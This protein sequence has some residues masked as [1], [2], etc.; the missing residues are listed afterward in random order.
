M[1]NFKVSTEGKFKIVKRINN[2]YY[3]KSWKY[4][5]KK[6]MW[7]GWMYVRDTSNNIV[8]FKE[9]AEALKYVE[10]LKQDIDNKN[11]EEIV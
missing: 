5:I 3:D 6:K 1:L 11:Y 7:I 2:N 10:K 8:M 4:A 9:H